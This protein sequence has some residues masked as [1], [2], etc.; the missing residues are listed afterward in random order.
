MNKEVW[1]IF[2]RKKKEETSKGLIDGGK[3]VGSIVGGLAIISLIF[4][5]IGL[6]VQFTNLPIPFL[7]EHSC[8][9]YY[10]ITMDN[11]LIYFFGIL[12]TFAFGVLIYEFCKWL[13]RNY[14]ESVEEAARDKLKK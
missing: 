10:C 13:M 11:G 8:S 5:V 7:V 3:F 14:D 9:T 6:I 4:F 1:K 2:F 12:F